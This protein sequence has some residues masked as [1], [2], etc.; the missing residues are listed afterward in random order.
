MIQLGLTSLDGLYQID[1][2]QFFLSNWA[3]SVKYVAPYIATRKYPLQTDRQ[4]DRQSDNLQLSNI[5][6]N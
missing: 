2:K 4:T 6:I 5:K 1:C 3:D